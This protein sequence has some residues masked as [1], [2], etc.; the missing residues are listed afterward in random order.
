MPKK[1]IGSI[2]INVEANLATLKAGMGEAESVVS[3]SAKKLA[4]QAADFAKAAGIA[5]AAAT[6][7]LVATVNATRSSIDE[8]AKF[9]DRIGVSTEALGGLQYSAELTGVSVNQLNL[10]LQRMTRRV[11]EAAKGT[12]EAK[13]ALKELG[14]DAAELNRQSPDEQFRKIAEAF[15]GVGGQADKVRLA[16]RLFDTE[17][18]ALVNTLKLGSEGLDAMQ[19]EAERLGIA[20]SRVDAAQVEAAN[21][22]ISGAAAVAKG[23]ANELTVEL[24]PAIEAV[25]LMYKEAALQSDEFVGSASL[26]GDLAVDAIGA[27]GDSIEEMILGWKESKAQVAEFAAELLTIGAKLDDFF[28]FGG[29]NKGLAESAKKQ[30]QYAAAYESIGKLY[31]AEFEKGFNDIE[32]SGNFSTR[33]AE[34]LEA[35]RKEI[36]N[37]I[38]TTNLGGGETGGST[39]LSKE[40]LQSLK[41]IE[42]VLKR[43]R[44]AVQEY[45]DSLATLNAAAATGK[46]GQDDY[47]T[48]LEIFKT[49]LNESTPEFEA[50]E[51]AQKDAEGIVNA[52]KTALEKLN[53][54]LARAKG[55]AASGVLPEEEFERAEARI[56]ETRQK[57][58]EAGKEVDKVGEALAQGM[59][60]VVSD[61]FVSIFQGG[62]DEVLAGFGDLII[63]MIAEAAAADLVNALGFGGKDSTGGNLSGLF[64]GLFSFDGGGYTGS[65]SRSGGLDGRGGFLSVLHPNET[66]VDHTK[67]QS[68]GGTTNNITFV[69]STNRQENDRALGQLQRRVT[70]TN[71]AGAR[72][73]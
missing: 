7:A 21:D 68:V 70:Q 24:A 39:G 41:E 25:A 38:N 23:F 45:E 6:A 63:G 31:R 34:Q 28:S 53:E 61:G 67:G 49:R 17:G 9:A 15:K 1:V 64:D 48:A 55:L 8:Q 71:A 47:N 4:S 14:L 59:Q 60:D 19:K 29:I 46:L 32:A 2:L 12:G 50:F 16:M 69:A 42:N 37:S 35:R 30:R 62:F 44:S 36:A 11:S 26:V 58:I 43:N 27:I 66:V 5:A 18:V 3:K 22:A 52:N 57:I 54:E 20:L 73:T 13:A 10:G 51:Q 56:E 33:F 65:G 72:M 40:Q